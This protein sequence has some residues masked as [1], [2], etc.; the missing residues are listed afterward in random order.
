MKISERKENES[1]RRYAH[2]VLETN[3]LDF[4]LKPG[5]YINEKEIC[6][7]LGISRTPV[8][9]ALLELGEVEIVNIFPQKGIRVAHIDDN[10]VEDAFFLRQSLECSIV[11]YAC[12]NST[13]KEK[14]ELEE[15]VNMQE[16]FLGKNI[17]K[18]LELDNEFHSKLFKICGKSRIYKVM[19][20]NIIHFE[21]IKNLSTRE[22]TNIRPDN[23]INMYN[24]HRAIVHALLM[25]DEILAYDS[26]I[27][28]INRYGYEEEFLR[29]KFKKYF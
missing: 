17:N 22:F 1:A 12:V 11:K 2:R 24:D 6:L 8:R 25:N 23:D 27:T 14:L 29:K 20:K 21:R 10:L 16:F 13:K 19:K 3:I 5:E 15:I 7:S 28:H 18:L 4:T 9:E 26:M